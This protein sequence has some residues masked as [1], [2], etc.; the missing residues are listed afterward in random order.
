MNGPHFDKGLRAAEDMGRSVFAYQWMMVFALK[1][2][3]WA[4][5]DFSVFQFDIDELESIVCGEWWYP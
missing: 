2:V 1:R 4:E 5:V 3:D